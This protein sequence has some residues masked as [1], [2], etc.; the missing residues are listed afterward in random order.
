MQSLDTAKH[1][2]SAPSRANVVDR[3]TV[4]Q[5]RA[6]VAAS[7]STPS[8]ESCW[9]C[10]KDGYGRGPPGRRVALRI[11]LARVRRQRRGNI[12]SVM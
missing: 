11:F 12:V 1:E 7:S 9:Q 4:K 8:P 10:G 5:P 6:G 3:L 2:A